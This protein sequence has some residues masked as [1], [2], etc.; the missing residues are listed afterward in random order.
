MARLGSW[1]GVVGR[2]LFSIPFIAAG[3][4]GFVSSVR[5]GRP[6]GG[7]FGLVFAG[8]G[9]ALAVQAIRSLQSPESRANRAAATGL[10][11]TREVVAVAP[12]RQAAGG[13]LPSARE[14]YGVAL[15]TLP[16]P[17]LPFR[18]GRV[19]RYGLGI[20]PSS[21]P[22]ALLAFFLVWN[23]ITVPVFVG[24]IAAGKLGTAV[25]TSVFVIV[26]VVLGVMVFRQLLGRRKLAL[27][28]ISS[29]PAFA[30]EEIELYVEQRGPLYLNRIEGK[31]RCEERVRYTV[32]TTTK[33]ESNVV[34]EEELFDE[35]AVA[36]SRAEPWSRSITRALPR[37]LHSFHA[38]KN[39]LVWSVALKADIANWPDYEESFVFRVVPAVTA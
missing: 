2:I 17:V 37:H 27:V 38:P 23:G 11:S 36:I 26:G 12:Y 9:A 29:E 5:D 32:G 4:F 35:I 33:T 6:S 15:P 13:K 3:L 31:L 7:V 19:L 30:G 16:V 20:D 25:F 22:W 18:K 1:A 28:E 39:E 8:V 24:T 14:L 10:A 34:Y 21:A